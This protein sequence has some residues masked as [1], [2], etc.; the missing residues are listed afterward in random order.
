MAGS[1]SNDGSVQ[2]NKMSNTGALINNGILKIGVGT[3]YC[4]VTNGATGDLSA[5]VFS[6]QG[7]SQSA[8][9]QGVT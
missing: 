6:F 5:L 1:L 4:N 9:F 3:V 7:T 2:T 8:V